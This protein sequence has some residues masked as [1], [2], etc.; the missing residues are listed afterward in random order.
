MRER[1][2][3]VARFNAIEVGEENGACRLVWSF[4]EEPAAEV[5]TLEGT[6]LP[7]TNRVDWSAAA[8]WKTYMQLTQ[9]ESAF[10]H[11][12]STLRLRPMRH[13]W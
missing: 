9:V 12:K 8:V 5:A 3:R 2:P 4:L 13:N 11:L 1:Y 6:C 7:R 10:R